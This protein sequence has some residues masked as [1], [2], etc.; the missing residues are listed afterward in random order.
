MLIGHDESKG[1]WE[2]GLDAALA[3]FYRVPHILQEFYKGKK[4]KASYYDFQAGKMKCTQG[5]ARLCPYYYVIGGKAVLAGVLATI[6][7]LDKKVIHGMVDAI[8]M[9]VAVK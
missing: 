9:P 6:V 1:V 5:R 4:V 7:P 8:M 3:S 2:A